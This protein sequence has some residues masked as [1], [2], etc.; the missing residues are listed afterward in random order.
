MS[1]SGP[2]Q[3][4]FVILIVLIAVAIMMLLYFVQI[5]AFFGPGLPSKPAGLEQHPWVLEKLLIPEGEGVKLPGRHKLQLNEPFTLTLPVSR[6]NT[7]RGKISIAFDINGRV[8]GQWQCS[9]EQAAIMYQ[10]E[11]ETNGNIDAKRTYQDENGEDKNRLFF[12]ARGHYTKTPLDQA[13]NVSGE[14]GQAWLTGWI[15]PDRTIEGY[16]TL[17]TDQQWAAAYAFK[18][19]K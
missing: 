1:K 8:Q 18:S 4:G 10:V 17:T 12:I 19:S 6:D 5:N 9:Y 13:S 7:D 15:R 3:K 16:I 14:K 2:S 11:A